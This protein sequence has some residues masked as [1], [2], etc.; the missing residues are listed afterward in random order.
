MHWF[1]PA[2]A[3]NYAPLMIA[4]ATLPKHVFVIAGTADQYVPKS[5]HDAV[6]SAA[7]LFQMSPQLGLPDGQTLL[8]ST[9]DYVEG[10][11]AFKERRAARFQGR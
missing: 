3:V 9:D 2:D 4:E 5:A 8:F 11:D 7:R 1:E 6:T 10:R